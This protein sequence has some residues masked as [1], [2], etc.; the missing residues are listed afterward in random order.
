MI[1]KNET[2]H[3]LKRLH[4][5]GNYRKNQQKF[6]R[7]SKGC[8]DE[9]KELNGWEDEKGDDQGHMRWDRTFARYGIKIFEWRPGEGNE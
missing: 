2:I 8:Y 7:A 6:G 1:K 9:E 3:F 5:Q 4:K